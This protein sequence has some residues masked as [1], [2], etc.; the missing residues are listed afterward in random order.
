MEIAKLSLLALCALAI[1]AAMSWPAIQHWR[2][3]R[4]EAKRRR[5]ERAFGDGC[6]V[7]P[8]PLDNGDPIPPRRRIDPE[9]YRRAADRTFGRAADRL[10]DEPCTFDR[11][12]VYS[13][14]EDC[15]CSRCRQRRATLLDR[16][17]SLPIWTHPAPSYE[18]EPR[19]PEFAG[20]GGDSGGAGASSS[21][22]SGS[23]SSGDSGGSSGGD[24][25][26]D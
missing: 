4:A 1:F 5:L 23:S 21:W 19:T 13:V 12:G 16:D 11:L 22:D 26:S 9:T 20:G 14:A 2:A 18:P 6:R 25:G 17:L 10:V 8:G 24:G 15:Q 3:Q 7:E